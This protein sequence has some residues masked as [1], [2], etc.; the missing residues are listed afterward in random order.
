M[1]ITMIKWHFMKT[2]L[3]KA[4]RIVVPKPLRDE[5]RLEP[6]DSLEIES[7]GDGLMLRPARGHAQL[8]KKHG[9]WVYRADE[10][11]SAATVRDAVRQIQEERDERNFG[12]EK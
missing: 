12:T 5:L 10:P 6:G 11:L 9:V 3:D 4:G 8:R 7:S 2:S 1:P